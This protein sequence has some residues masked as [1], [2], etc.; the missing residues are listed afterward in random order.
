[1]RAADLSKLP[2][3]DLQFAPTNNLVCERKLSVFSRR[4]V[5]AKSKN[6]KHTGELLRDNMVLHNAERKDLSIQASKIKKRLDEM[7]VSWYLKQKN[8]QLEVM[9]KKLLK[10]Q[11]NVDYVLK[12]AKTCKT[13]GGPCCSV[14]ELT[15][16][17]R[18]NSD[19]DKK[20]S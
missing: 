17:L 6:R 10:K 16:V 14:D 13:W 3:N 15:E 1:M 5:T 9:E 7:N 2:D 20:N 4:S 19:I 8:R 18:K 11:K 12:L